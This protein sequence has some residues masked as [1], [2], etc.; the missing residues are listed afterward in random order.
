[1]VFKL[2]V[3][4]L[5]E[6]I[7]RHALHSHHTITKLDFHQRV[8]IGVPDDVIVLIIRCFDVHIFVD[9]VQVDRMHHVGSKNH[10]LLAVQFI[11]IHIFQ[12][13]R[14][15]VGREDLIHA[16]EAFDH[17]GDGVVL[18]D[19]GIHQVDIAF[20]AV[21]HHLITNGGGFLVLLHILEHDLN[22]AGNGIVHFHIHSSIR[23]RS[24]CAFVSIQAD[25]S[26]ASLSR[27]AGVMA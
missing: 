12:L 22:N 13:F 26:A 20:L 27:P 18:A 17:G 2:T 15:L 7:S 1:M 3:I 21:V 16:L 6:G 9:Q 23:S 14:L 4:L 11:I 25:W 10:M 19:P 24:I 8:L 5:F